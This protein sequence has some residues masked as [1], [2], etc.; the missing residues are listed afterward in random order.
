M[1]MRS[2][3]DHERRAILKGSRQRVAGE[4]SDFYES[5]Q[6]EFAPTS[7]RSIGE[8]IREIRDL[9]D[10]QVERI[11]EHQRKH[12][13]RF[14]ESAVALRMASGDEVLWA[15][16]Q[17][18]DYPYAREGGLKRS[19]EL[20]A[21]AEPFGEQAEAF[22]ELRSQLLA[23]TEAPRRAYAIVSPDRGDGRSYVAANLAI[24]FSQL[25][26]RTLLL[27]ADMRAPTQHRLF[28]RTGKLGLSGILA[29]HVGSSAIQTVPGL[30]SLYVLAV[31]TE[32]P[33]PQ[34]LIQR[35]AFGSLL[36][37]VIARF[38]HVVVDTPAGAIGADW[39][40][41]AAACG[42][43]VMIGR[44]HRTRMPD[45]GRM[46]ATIARSRVRLAGVVMNDF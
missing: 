16:S 25:G 12:G 40:V 2:I 31:G 7:E 41:I 19:R 23:D 42:G 18:F 34:E 21:A 35:P 24:A 39:R 17:Q 43:A 11:V 45:L 30:P 10:A 14:G 5:L 13:T 44:R 37:R 22:R 20:V 27:D 46:K 3:D 8:L 33:N 4:Q 1:K 29:G 38:D 15:L 26:E 6:S 9:T 36:Q 32:P 28:G